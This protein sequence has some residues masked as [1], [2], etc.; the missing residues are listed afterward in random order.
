[1]DNLKFKGLRATV[2]LLSTVLF[3][4]IAIRGERAG[5]LAAAEANASSFVYTMTNPTGPNSIASFHRDPNTGSLSFA[6]LYPTGGNGHRQAVATTQSSIVTNGTFLYAVNAG[7][8]DISAFAIEGDGSLRSIGSPIVSG[9]LAPTTLALYGNLLYVGNQGAS[10][11][12]ANYT[13]FLVNT[14]GSLS[15]LPDSTVTLGIGD[16]I[17]DVLFDSTGS[18]LFGVRLKAGAIDMFS[19]APTGKLAAITTIAAPAPFGAEFNPANAGQLLVTLVGLPGAGSYAVLPDTLNLSGNAVDSKSKDPC[20]TA[21]TKSGAF[22]WT[23]NFRP[24]TLSLFS[25]NSDGT[26]TFRGEHETA[27]FGGNSADIILDTRGAFLYQLL[28]F[29]TSGA[30]IHVMAVDDNSVLRDVM[31]VQIPT[32]HSF[33]MGLVIVDLQ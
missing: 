22:L 23:S 24:S 19:V 30:G 1:M 20:W 26:L 11:T 16:G 32:E 3:L 31:T 27:A 2:R 21:I 18:R 8:N 17:T 4:M 25:I 13:G 6:A 33:P 14:D 10:R 28:P 29:P 9:G 7:S 5:A 15:P 12:P